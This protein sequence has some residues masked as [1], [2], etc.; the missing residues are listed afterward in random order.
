MNTLEEC[1]HG[2]WGSPDCL[3][4]LEA[5]DSAK[6]LLISDTHSRVEI[7]RGILKDFGAACDA[8]IFAGDG[9]ADIIECCEEALAEENVRAILPPLIAVVAGNSDLPVYSVASKSGSEAS[10]QSGSEA[11]SQSGSEASSLKDIER[12]VFFK[13]PLTQILTVC[14]K[15]IL[16]THGHLYSVNS[17]IETLVNT[18]RHNECSIAV[19]GHTHIAAAQAY[20]SVFAINPGSA[21]LPRGD[22]RASFAVLKINASSEQ[23]EYSFYQPGDGIPPFGEKPGRRLY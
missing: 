8:L 18:A 5:A 13:A 21:C 20:K 12:R 1:R 15:K 6:L 4:S 22:S 23:P 16:V 19:Y 10:S 7:L 3:A 9:V 14:G 2:I 11:S 17:S